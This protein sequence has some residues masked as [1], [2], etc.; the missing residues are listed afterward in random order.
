MK[1]II[2]YCLLLI[3][4]FGCR[5]ERLELVWSE[6]KTPKTEALEEVVF[7]N[8]DTGYVVGGTRYESGFLMTTNDGGTSWKVDSL[9]R[10]TC[11]DIDLIDEN[12]IY[13]IGHYGHMFQSFNNGNT[14]QKRSLPALEAYWNIDFYSEAQGVA[15]GGNAYIAG[16]T[17]LFNPNQIGQDSFIKEEF[18]E[19][20]D[21]VFVN[22]QTIVAVGY[23]VVKRSTDGGLNFETLPVNGDNFTAVHFPTTQVG[24]AVGFSGAILKST[25]AGATWAVLQ[26]ANNFTKPKVSFND[27]YFTDENHGYL[28]GWNGTFW[29]T[30]NGG[31]DWQI[32]KNMPAERFTSVFVADGKGYI[33][34]KEG[35]LFQFLDN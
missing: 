3:T 19:M 5:K 22:Q 10:F 18:H 29:I 1:P 34:S 7:K 4:A 17:F 35:H 24:Y 21:A 31:D 2:F 25:D 16:G 28:V 12:T 6:I 11:Y 20:N 23:G 32:I 8:T 30:E 27:V 14:W 15:V 13:I 26:K 33:T 9:D